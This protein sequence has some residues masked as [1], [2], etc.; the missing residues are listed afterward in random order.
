MSRNVI[1]I[2]KDYF[3]FECINVASL[4]RGECFFRV[5]STSVFYYTKWVLKEFLNILSKTFIF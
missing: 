3:L 5:F 2:D 4:I 1:V